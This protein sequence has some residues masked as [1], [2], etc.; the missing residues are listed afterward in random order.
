M[1]GVEGPCAN[2]TNPQ[3]DALA[4]VLIRRKIDF[5]CKRMFRALQR[6]MPGILYIQ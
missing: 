2:T 4:Q 1:D 3:W 6:L 5:N